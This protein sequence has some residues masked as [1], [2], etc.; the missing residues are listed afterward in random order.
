MTDFG[1]VETYSIVWMIIGL[2]IFVVVPVALGIIWTIKK[3]ERVTT[4]LIGAAA[5]ILFA[6]ILEKS[7]QNVL[8]FPTAMMLPDHTI[9]LFFNSHPV[10]LALLVGLFPGVFEETGRLVAYKT[11]LRNRKNKETSIS[12]GI[13]HGGIEVVAILGL[14]YINYIAYAIMINTGA[15]QTI[16]DQ[17][18]VQAPD[19]IGQVNQV[20]ALITTFSG[21]NVMLAVVE[22]IFSVMFHIGASILVFYACRDKGKFWLYPLAIV[23]HTAMDFVAGLVIFNV[24]SISDWGMELIVAIMGIAVFFG[25][26]FLLYKKDNKTVN[27][28]FCNH[29]PES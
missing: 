24:I 25:S 26:Y 12:Y 6:M 8:L 10:M 1:Y 18:M 3:K 2:F 11:V 29:K 9:S 27:T 14:T 19:Q 15:F 20:V 17:L 23:L 21:G 16:V 22:R 5:F 4:I 13:G 28:I 7:I